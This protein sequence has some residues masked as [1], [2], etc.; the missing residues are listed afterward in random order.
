MPIVTVPRLLLSLVSLIILGAAIY[1][2]WSW[3]HGYELR[4][5]DGSAR[6]VHGAPWKLYTALG[7]FTWSLL[8]RFVVLLCISAGQDEPREERT[9]GKVVTAPDGSALHV[10]TFAGVQAKGTSPCSA[11]MRR[12]A[13]VTS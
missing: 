6:H 10:E 3:G 1:L 11:G 9:S 12:Q 4:L 5:A 8:G 13:I 7:L 2:L